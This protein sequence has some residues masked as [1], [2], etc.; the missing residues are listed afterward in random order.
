MNNLFNLPVPGSPRFERDVTAALARI[1]GSLGPTGQ[2]TFSNI[3]LSA[4]TVTS[5][6]VGSLSGVLKASAGVVSGGAAHSA[7][8]GIGAN[9]H[10]NAV[11]LGTANGLTLSTQELS[12]PT[13][14]SPTLATVRA[15]T[16]FNFN[17]TAGV[18]GTLVLDDGANWRVTVVIGGGIITSVSSAA[19]SGAAAIWTPA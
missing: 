15:N 10:H 18:S 9:D 16:G 1:R 8:S 17:G 14:A 11:T 2:P 7:L 13:T 4:T 6:T 19:S 3:D 5:L 12:L